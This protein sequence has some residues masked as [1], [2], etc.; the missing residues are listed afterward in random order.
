MT[1]EEAKQA[2]QQL[3]VQMYAY[4][5]ALGQISLDAATVGPKDTV[6]GRGVAL[7]VLAGAMYD[8]AMKPETI[9]L[10]EYLKAHKDELNE[11][12]AKEVEELLR[13]H[14]ETSKIPKDEYLA[15]RQLLNEAD[16]VWHQAKADDDFAA[17]LPVLEKI[18]DFNRKMA[19]YI[20]PEK[21][22]YD[23][24]LDRYERGLTM[25]KADAFFAQVRAHIVPLLAKIQAAP[26]VDDSF[27]K[28]IFPVEKQRV[29][30]DRLMEMQTIDR[31]HCAIGETEHPFTSGFNH[32]DVRITT[33]YYEDNFSDSMY[34]VIHEGGH[35]LYEL[36][37]D[38]ALDYTVLSGG[39]SMGIHESQSRLFENIIGRSRGYVKNLL[40]VL[41]EIF[42][43]Q[44]EGVTAEALYKAL[45]KVEPSLIRTKADE[46]TYSLHIMVRYEIEKRLIDGTLECKDVPAE[47]NRLYKEYLG[48]DVPN[49]RDGC[50]QDTHWGGGMIGYFPSYALGSAYGAQMVEK[51]KEDIDYEACLDACDL[52][53]IVAW[54]GEKIHKYGSSKDPAWI[55]ANCLQADFDPSYYT[56]YLE[57]KY[58]DIYG[59]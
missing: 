20:H 6:E 8:M 21:K 19:G 45:N 34:S 9:E 48:V 43:E 1:I 32:A 22:P 46:L 39:V 29:L 36:G 50:L 12:E 16:A 15:Y 53:P 4:R 35:A 10:L 11:L 58:S 18:V 51:M 7:S 28:Q 26:Q 25:E 13:D 5:Y 33:H 54:L 38:P 2:L 40:P 55:L 56:R 37:I 52:K 30:S 17:F 23:A 31:G 49:D 59:L 42:P 24:L 44:M 47:W 41:Q 27:L 57:A 3:Q 14:E